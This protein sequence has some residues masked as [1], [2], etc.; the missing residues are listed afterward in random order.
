MAKKIEV[1]A[2]I[3][4]RYEDNIDSYY[5]NYFRFRQTSHECLLEFGRVRPAGFETEDEV[6]ETLELDAFMQGEI[7]LSRE[8]AQQLCDLLVRQLHDEGN[9]DNDEG[10][11]P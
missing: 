10:G 2:H 1:K 6:P 3:V 11:E 8:V 7:W 9:D 5:S 4:P